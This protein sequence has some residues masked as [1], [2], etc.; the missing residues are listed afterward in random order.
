MFLFAAGQGTTVDLLASA[1]LA[2]ADDAELQQQL[3]QDR[4]LI[5]SF[6]EEMLRLESPVKSNFRLARRTTTV[7]EL[8]VSAGENVMLMVGAAN[9]DPRH[10]ERP[11]ELW[12]DRPNLA[13]HLAFG[14]GIHA[15][16]GAPLARAEARVALERILD[17]M[18]DIRI[19]QSVHG[20]RE[21]ST[22]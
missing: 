20:P 8:P 9:R 14:R 11:A 21:R 15:C 19:D 2:L 16:P 3:R 10:F 22:L 4:S 6:I 12:L 13:E 5:P 18:G 7:G 17:R 1:L